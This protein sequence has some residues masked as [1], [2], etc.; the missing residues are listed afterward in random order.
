MNTKMWVSVVVIVLVVVGVY[1][2]L[3]N[4]G[5]QKP[6]I[7]DQDQRENQKDKDEDVL[8]TKGT[9]EGGLGF[10]SEGIPTDLVVCAENEQGEE[11]TC[12]EQI[13]DPKYLNGTGYKMELVP[14]QYKVYAR[15]PE[16]SG[17][18]DGYK[19]YYNEFVVCGLSVECE[20]H[21]PIVI[22]LEAGQTVSEI[23]PIDWYNNSGQ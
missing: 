13:K 17:G 22:N 7:T 1:F 14:A 4:R 9:I 16:G 19:A 18:F 12:V 21:E 8:V 3:D 6:D 10:P 20:S 2:L 23:N 15:F 11:V 5:D